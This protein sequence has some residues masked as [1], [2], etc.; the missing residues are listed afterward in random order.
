VANTAA[1]LHDLTPVAE[2]L[3]GEEEVFYGDAG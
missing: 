1:N 2:I 3:H